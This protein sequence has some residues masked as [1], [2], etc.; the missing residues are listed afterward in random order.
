MNWKIAWK[1]TW[2]FVG[3]VGAVAAM[4]ATAPWSCIVAVILILWWS[5]YD[6]LLMKDFLE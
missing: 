1:A 3:V 6:T 2:M 5:I 4:T